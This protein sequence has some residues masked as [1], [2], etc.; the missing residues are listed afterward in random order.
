[1]SRF[2]EYRE[3]FAEAAA[4]YNEEDDYDHELLLQQLL[5]LVMWCISWMRILTFNIRRMRIWML[6]EAFILS[7][8]K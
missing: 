4:K 2:M 5:L 3:V 7:V 1:M 8:G 6:I